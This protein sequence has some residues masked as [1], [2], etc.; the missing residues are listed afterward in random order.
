MLFLHSIEEDEGR[1][2]DGLVEAAVL[3]LAQV[4]LCLGECLSSRLS[5]S[6]MTVERRHEYLRGLIVH[7]PEAHDKGFRPRLLE[8]PLQSEHAIAR[9]ITQSSLTGRQHHEVK[10]TQVV[11]SSGNAQLMIVV[12]NTSK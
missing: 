8:P 1:P 6:Q 4:T 5:F 3:H 7:F 11:Q 10:T 12:E 2:V 9:D